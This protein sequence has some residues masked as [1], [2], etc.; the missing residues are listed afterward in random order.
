MRPSLKIGFSLSW[1]LLVAILIPGIIRLGNSPADNCSKRQTRWK[2]N[3]EAC[4][5]EL[6][7]C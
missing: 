6:L 1:I 7:E 4:F 3:Q 5:R 2:G